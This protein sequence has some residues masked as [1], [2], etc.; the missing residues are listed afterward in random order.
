MVYGNGLGI[1]FRPVIGSKRMDNTVISQAIGA[2][3]SILSA[4]A[5]RDKYATVHT[6]PICPSAVITDGRY[7]WYSDYRKDIDDGKR[8]NKYPGTKQTTAT[9]VPYA[10]TCLDMCTGM[11]KNALFRRRYETSIHTKPE[12]RM[13][14]ITIEKKTFD[15]MSEK[16]DRFVDR[17]EE[18]CRRC[19]E[20]GMGEWLDNQDVCRLLNI[21]PRTLQTLRDNGTLAYSRI[22]Q[23]I[24]YKP[25]DVRRIL[26]V[27]EERRKEAVFR[28]R[29]I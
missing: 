17:V 2:D 21:S 22:N 23:K 28:K 15:E 20:R 8:T 26:P 7:T 13:E 3:A 12:K 25:Q 1:Y 29:T 27:V 16:F 18:I 4:I 14:V 10:A 11:R 6:S 24:Y 19:G 9:P 5:T